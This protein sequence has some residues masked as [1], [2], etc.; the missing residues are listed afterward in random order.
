MAHL[1]ALLHTLCRTLDPRLSPTVD[2]KGSAAMVAVQRSSGVAPEVNLNSPLHASDEAYNGGIHPSLETQSSHHQKS[3]T[4]I[5]VKSS[6]ICFLKMCD[7]SYIYFTN[8][9]FIL[10]VAYSTWYRGRLG[11]NG[12]ILG[13][14]HLQISALRTRRSLLFI[15]GIFCITICW[16]Y[17]C[18]QKLWNVTPV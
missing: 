10:A 11:S 3:K 7:D 18:K 8:D 13:T 2:Q 16:Q 17:S 4:R 15:G 1:V 14:S 9:F 5:L 6:N 12:K